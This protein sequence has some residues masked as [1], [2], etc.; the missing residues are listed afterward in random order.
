[1]IRVALYVVL[2]VIAAAVIQLVFASFLPQ[3][4]DYIVYAQ[5]L[6]AVGFGYLIVSG[7]ASFIYWSMRVKCDHAA[8]AAIRNVA[9]VIGIGALVQ[10]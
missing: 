10:L 5:I 8:A 4:M 6:L 2:Y 7:A 9:R 3:L 1:M